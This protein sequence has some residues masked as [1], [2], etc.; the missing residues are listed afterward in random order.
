MKTKRLLAAL[1]VLFAMSANL[2]ATEVT[3]NGI[4]YDVIKKGKTAKVLSNSPKYSG[5]IVIH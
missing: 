4:K 1:F 5:N 3:I 2:W